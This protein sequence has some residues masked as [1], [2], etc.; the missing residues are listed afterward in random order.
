MLPI[1]S[2]GRG[3]VGSDG[4]GMGVSVLTLSCFIH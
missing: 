1:G 3:I 4:A 2:G